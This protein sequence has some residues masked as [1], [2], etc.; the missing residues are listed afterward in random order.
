MKMP[1]LSY[2][3]RN[4]LQYKQMVVLQ[5]VSAGIF[6]VSHALMSENI[7]HMQF[8]KDQISEFKA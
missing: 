5:N 2:E 7:K 3:E 8:T 1:F 6:D 4:K